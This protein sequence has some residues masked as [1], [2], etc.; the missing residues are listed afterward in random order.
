MTKAEKEAATL[1]LQALEM[2]STDEDIER[3]IESG[4]LT[5][6]KGSDGRWYAWYYDKA[7]E[8]I[9]RVSDL[10]IISP[11]RAEALFG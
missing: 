4:Y 6:N 1:A 8:A 10:R 3:H 5:F 7:Q 11:K 9:I 2:D